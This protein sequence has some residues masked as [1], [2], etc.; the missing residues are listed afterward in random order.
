MRI[1]HI[2]A[3]GVVVNGALVG[4]VVWQAGQ[5]EAGVRTVAVVPAAEPSVTNEEA[6]AVPLPPGLTNV[7]VQR[8]F[9]WKDVESDDYLQLIANL[10]RA[11]CP[12]ATI[13]DIVVSRA[14][15]DY[16]GRCWD[17]LRPMQ[18]EFWDRLARG[19]ALPRW[20]L[21]DDL[22]RQYRDLQARRREV[23]DRLNKELAARSKPDEFPEAAYWNFLTVEDQAAVRGLYRQFAERIA[24]INEPDKGRRREAFVALA[25]ERD[26]A[27]RQLVGEDSWSEYELRR[28]GAAGWLR[29]TAGLALN[30]EQMRQLLELWRTNNVNPAKLTAAETRAE[31][32]AVAGPESLQRSAKGEI[33]HKVA[34]RH[35]LPATVAIRAAD[36]RATA[37]AEAIKVRTYADDEV[38]ARAAAALLLGVR[39]ELA[40]IYGDQA[41]P[42]LE[43]YG[44]AWLDDLFAEP[45]P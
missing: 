31:I 38:R 39:Q 42:T 15:E 27:L 33:F 18:T 36:V 2:L 9:F 1:R 13:R 28:S 12:D 45:R 40:G 44:L 3:L 25:K 23:L 43:K 5:K 10:R 35:G 21:S 32:A 8:P 34:R 20:G 14:E 11:G 22:E 7:V 24:A 6:Y 16:A 37:E 30:E 17:L 26:E 4:G 19:E 41:W 29:S